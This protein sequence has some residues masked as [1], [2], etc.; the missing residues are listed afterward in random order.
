VVR[1]A[2]GEGQD[3]IPE[4]REARLAFWKFV[5]VAERDPTLVLTA[6]ASEDRRNQIPDERNAQQRYREAVQEESNLREQG[7]PRHPAQAHRRVW[8]FR[9]LAHPAPPWKSQPNTTKNC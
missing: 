1:V 2:I 7:A 3:W 4:C 6:I 8:R 5:E 9:L